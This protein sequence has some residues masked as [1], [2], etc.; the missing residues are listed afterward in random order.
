[1]REVGILLLWE[2]GLLGF[3]KLKLE[4]KTII[5]PWLREKPKRF[6]NRKNQ[7]PTRNLPNTKP[8]GPSPKTTTYSQKPSS[9]E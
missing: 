6:R 4:D 2:R 5:L 7:T 3:F 1:M 8:S 9:R